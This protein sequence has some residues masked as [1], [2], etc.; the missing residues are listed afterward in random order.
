MT[1]AVAYAIATLV[2][3]LALSPAA[4]AA[5]L[6]VAQAEEAVRRE[7]RDPDSVHFRN[8]HLYSG[9]SPGWYKF[10]GEFNARNGFGG[11]TG[12]QHFL[13]DVVSGPK[14]IGAVVAEAGLTTD[15]AIQH[16]EQ[17]GQRCR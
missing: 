16:V 10:C 1:P 14:G 4:E 12:F 15:F 9:V 17:T 8:V 5:P 11:Y 7:M 6:S 13:A 2:L 3:G